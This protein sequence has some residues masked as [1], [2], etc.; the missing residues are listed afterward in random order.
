MRAATRPTPNPAS[1]PM[2]AAS[3]TTKIPWSG[4]PV[5]PER[6]PVA[7]LSEQPLGEVEPLLELLQP[8]ALVRDDFGLLVELSLEGGKLG[9][10]GGAAARRPGLRDFHDGIGHD[11]G[12]D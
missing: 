2:I 5:R 11:P 12:H 8:V 9:A 3:V 1:A 10:R 6:L 4:R 7:G